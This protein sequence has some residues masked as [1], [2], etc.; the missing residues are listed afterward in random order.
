MNYPSMGH[1]LDMIEPFSKEEKSRMVRDAFSTL[2]GS[3][4]LLELASSAYKGQIEAASEPAPQVSRKW[5]ERL[6]MGE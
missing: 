6:L 1:V 2:E 3:R 5:Y 4:L